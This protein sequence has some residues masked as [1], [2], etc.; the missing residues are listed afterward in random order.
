MTHLSRK[1]TVVGALLWLLTAQYYV[2]EVITARAW[3]VIP[4]GPYNTISD[5]GA[6]HCG[7]LFGLSYACSPLHT[8]MNSSFIAT[9]VLTL[10]GLT[11]LRRRFPQTSAVRVVCTLIA[12]SS[13]GTILVGV[14]PENENIAV[15]LF[16]AHCRSFSVT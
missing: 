6:T 3:Q 7:T 16:G 1:Q 14:F 12:L 9:G 5:L 10:V 4:Y 2:A 11:L 8:L 13:V 15:H